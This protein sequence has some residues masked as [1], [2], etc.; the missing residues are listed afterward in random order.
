MM[1]AAAVSAGLARRSFRPAFLGAA[2]FTASAPPTWKRSALIDCSKVQA[3]PDAYGGVGAF[4][5]VPIKKGELVERGVV[6]IVPADGN[7][8]PYVFTWSEDRSVW[9][10]GSGVSIFYNAALDGKPNSEMERHLDSDTFKIFAVRDIEQGEELTHVYKSLEW[11]ECFK[12][13]KALRD[14]GKAGPPVKPNPLGPP[15][16]DCSKVYAKA[17]GHGGVGAFA[18]QPIKKGEVVEYGI[19]RRLP[20]DGHK[21]TILFT[22]S[23]DRTVWAHASGLAP[24]YNTALDGSENT[25]MNRYFDEDRFDIIAVRDIEEDEELTHVYRSID[26]RACFGDLKKAREAIRSSS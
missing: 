12:E 1:R 7:I 13:L 15:V 14:S 21:S 4:A 18:A 11:R 17:D 9:A 6:R 20:V 8:C 24:F 19:V 3:R 22:W 2:R 25:K 10:S 26:W 23:E 5:A 16:L